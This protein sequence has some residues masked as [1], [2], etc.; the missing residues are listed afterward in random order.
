MDVSVV[1]P[2]YRSERTLGHLLTRLIAVLEEC[3][4]A[5]E[6]LLVVDGS[7]DGTWK[8]AAGLAEEHRW[9]NAIH[10]SRNYGQHNALLAGLR[11]ARLP[12]VVTMDDDLQHPPE[13]IPKLLSAL[14]DDVDLVYGVPIDDE[15]DAIR[16]FASRTVKRAMARGLEIPNAESISAFRAFRTY[17][18]DA[19][20]GL[21]GPHASVDVALSWSTTRVATQ[22]V[23]MDQRA[24]GRSNYS[25]RLLVKHAMN[26]LLGYS[27]APLRLV[28]YLGFF[29]GFVGALMLA[30]VLWGYVTGNTTVAGWT[31]VASMIAVFSGA[32]MVSIAVVGEYVGRVHANN[33]GR[34]T[35]L[36]RQ[37]T[38]QHSGRSDVRSIS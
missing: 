13:E 30:Y 1:I 6:V 17:L 15:H 2:C 32:Q 33:M 36:I 24:E 37:R 14:T 27:V 3:A 19:S 5:Y 21:T 34:P 18:R 29:C 10:L 28:G 26:M 12:V 38:D 16:N 31:S 22:R 11:C 20:A 25:F 9:V 8:V 7:P 4:G 23:R 35:Y